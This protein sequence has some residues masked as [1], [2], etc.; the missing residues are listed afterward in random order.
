LNAGSLG[1]VQKFFGPKSQLQNPRV[2]QFNEVV[3]L[4]P[5]VTESSAFICYFSIYVSQ[6]GGGETEGADV[7]M[8]FAIT[9][10]DLDFGFL[11]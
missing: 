6:A 7:I 10:E 11:V 5:R 3:K 2:L 4:H 8:S 1:K 9:S